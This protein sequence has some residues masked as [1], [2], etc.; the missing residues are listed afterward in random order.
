MDTEQLER[1][2]SDV[3]ATR[4]ELFQLI[5]LVYN[6][7]H[8]A[9]VALSYLGSNEKKI[10]F[11][12]QSLNSLLSNA[13]LQLATD[14]KVKD[15][16]SW[17]GT[18]HEMRQILSTSLKILAPDEQVKAKTWYKSVDNRDLP[19]QNQRVKYILET[20]HRSSTQSEVTKSICTLDTLLEEL[21][22]SY[23]GRAS[24][25]AH[26]GTDLDEMIKLKA[27]FDIFAMDLFNLR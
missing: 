14:L 8:S 17:V 10:Y 23:Y 13:Y 12:L 27:Y 15:R 9:I 25:A 19:T 4:V 21:I 11:F 26:R 22:R 24:D 2:N 18:A 3:G 20:N 7:Q 5:G 16:I 6:P 1:I